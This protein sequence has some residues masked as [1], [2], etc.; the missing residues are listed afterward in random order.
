M[1]YMERLLR[2][3]RQPVVENDAAVRLLPTLADAVED[4]QAE[5]AALREKLVPIALSAEEGAR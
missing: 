4:L 2:E 3:A 5:L 1:N